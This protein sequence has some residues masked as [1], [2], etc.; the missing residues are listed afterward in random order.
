MNKVKVKHTMASLKMSLKKTSR[1][2]E[3]VFGGNY[4]NFTWY[5]S[6]PEHLCILGKDSKVLD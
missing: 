6:T 3:K 2:L 1:K 4:S 5:A